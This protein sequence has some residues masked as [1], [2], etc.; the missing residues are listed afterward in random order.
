MEKADVSIISSINLTED[1][2]ALKEMIEVSL[3]WFPASFHIRIVGGP[4]CA[5][6]GYFALKIRY[7]YLDLM[8]AKQ[9]TPSFKQD[10]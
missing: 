10:V 9:P 6:T 4:M 1:N 3:R 2:H 7:C 5:G 8:C